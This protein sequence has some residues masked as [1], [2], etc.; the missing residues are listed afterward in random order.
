M[1]TT[2]KPLSEL[3]RD[4]QDDARD[5]LGMVNHRQ[6]AEL[7]IANLDADA[8]RERTLDG[9]ARMSKRL[10]QS[11]V[12]EIVAADQPDLFFS[13][14]H[15]AYAVLS[16]GEACTKKTS[17]L[18]RAQFEHAIKLREDGVKA[19]TKHLNIMRNVLR[20][21]GPIWDRN[22]DWVFAQVCKAFA[23]AHD[24]VPA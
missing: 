22:P 23:E 6:V 5:E 24:L 14:L 9:L 18:T 19:D 2:V 20:A 11:A 13:E 8:M 1:E 12:A 15:G 10:A 3:I 4:A 17:D 16:D 7:V 21:V